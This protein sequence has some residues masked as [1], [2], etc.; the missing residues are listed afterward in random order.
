MKFLFINFFEATFFTYS[1]QI[2]PNYYV[3]DKYKSDFRQQ[4]NR[5]PG[6]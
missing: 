1:F 6:M 3:E 5:D 2:F 4:L